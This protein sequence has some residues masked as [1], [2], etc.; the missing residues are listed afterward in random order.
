M[1]FA[2]ERIG[3]YSGFGV[4]GIA[5]SIAGVCITAN[6]VFGTVESNKFDAR[7]FVDNVDG[8]LEVAVDARRV[9]NQSDALALQ[10]AETAVAK[11]FHA[12][13]NVCRSHHGSN[14]TQY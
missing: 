8:R 9:G 5:D 13:F 3:F 2:V 4:D 7:R 10:L 1:G 11:H 14:G 12:R 6:A